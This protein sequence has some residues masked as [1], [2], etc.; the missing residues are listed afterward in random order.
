MLAQETPSNLT[1]NQLEGP[2]SSPHLK[3]SKPKQLG[4][5]VSTPPPPHIYH[6][7][8]RASRLERQALRPTG[9]TCTVRG[10]ALTS[11]RL[12]IGVQS[13]HRLDLL[14][15]HLNGAFKH[16]SNMEMRSG[17][18]LFGSEASESESRN[19]SRSEIQLLKRKTAVKLYIKI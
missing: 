18:R 19:Y 8:G 2:F 5:Q 3:N 6:Q 11:I 4:F 17:F 14:L 1:N 15:T 12:K 9:C 7:E 13:L 16:D 10:K